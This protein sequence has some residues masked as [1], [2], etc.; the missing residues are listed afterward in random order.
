MNILV[1]DDERTSRTIVARLIA[2]KF[3]YCQ[4]TEAE[5]GIDAL[6]VLGSEK[7]DFLIIDLNMPGMSGLELVQTLRKDPAYQQVP[8]IVAS[9]VQ[10]R[11]TVVKL[12]QLGISGYLVKPLDIEVA[13]QKIGETIQ[14]IRPKAKSEIKASRQAGLVLILEPNP[15]QRMYFLG[16]V[17]DRCTLVFS[18]KE[19]DVLRMIKEYDPTHVVLS[20]IDKQTGIIGERMIA[21]KI[22]EQFPEQDI[23]ILKFS[24]FDYLLSDENTYFTDA[25]MRSPNPSIMLDQF[26]EKLFNEYSAEHKIIHVLRFHAVDKLPELLR[27]VIPAY[28]HIRPAVMERGYVGR[29][30][31]EYA[32]RIA[33]D[34]QTTSRFSIFLSI[35][36]KKSEI[37]YI[38][39]KSIGS[40]ISPSVEYAQSVIEKT[41]MTIADRLTAIMTRY[42]IETERLYS[43]DNSNDIYEH[44]QIWDTALPFRFRNEGEFLLTMSLREH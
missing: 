25:L 27:L 36:G 41:L 1:V 31:P 21:R 9:V 8:I 11:T 19:K 38:V 2:K 16:L 29:I 34:V 40:P 33:V 14:S 22:R 39:S 5:N 42:G 13:Q 30:E 20:D 26:L 24:N 10:D 7:I 12:M 18:D 17:G 6:S 28:F 23:S 15:M 35:E 44:A 43:V 32:I 37:L 3:P 4:V